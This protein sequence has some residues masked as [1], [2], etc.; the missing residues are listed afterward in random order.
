MA[1]TA[2]SARP[3]MTEKRKQIAEPLDPHYYHRNFLELIAF[4]DS[5]YRHLLNDG[6]KVFLDDYRALPLSAQQL[7]C[8]LVMRTRRYF[9]VS[10][11]AYPEIAE[12]DI[13]LDE[14]VTR[15]FCSAAKTEEAAVWV[16]L[17]RRDELQ[18]VLP[19]Q[20]GQRHSTWLNN[21]TTDLLL[22]SDLFGFTPLDLLRQLD[23]IYCTEHKDAFV[24]FQLLFFGDLHQDISSFVLRD[25]GLTRYESTLHQ[26][27]PLPF[28]SRTQLMAHRAYFDCITLYDDAVKCD[29]NALVELQRMLTHCCGD[30]AE[31]DITLKRRVEKWS[32]RI[33]RQLERVGAIDDAATIY[34]TITRPPARERLTRIRVKQGRAHDALALC[35][36][37][38]LRP[39]DAAELD[40]AQ[41][42]AQPLA[43]ALNE[44][45]PAVK[46]YSP[47][48]LSLTLPASKLPVEYATALHYAKTGKCFYVE[49]TLFTSVFGLAM[50][51]II[52]AP[53]E[54]AFFHPFQT[55]PSDFHASEFTER[56][57]SRFDKRL[58]QI[59]Q[60]GLAPFVLPNLHHKCGI[61]NP[62]V[63]WYAS[64][65]S[66]IIL[67][68][69]R[70]PVTDW[71]AIFEYLLQDIPAHRSGLPDLLYLPD[72]GSYL[73]LE[74]KGPGDQLQKHQRRWMKYF[75][76][77][78]IPHGVVNV[79]YT[80]EL[81][82][83]ALI[84]LECGLSQCTAQK[85]KQDD[86]QSS[87]RGTRQSTT[88][89]S[90]Q[91]HVLTGYAEH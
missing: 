6:E 9:R 53:I 26:D 29:R 12:P 56:R 54:G 84:R 22:Q 73:L 13:A 20:P 67:A 91:T 48:A 77:C 69:E 38:T 81:A 30:V 80:G 36:A 34:E 8:R 37:I 23:I 89:G 49:N 75:E 18:S 7:Y 88:R 4:V 43:K 57:R 63:N 62:L 1:L 70:I 50:W 66:L 35:K 28:T 82:D 33:A 47:P 39:G 2:N 72:D 25:L 24:N 64:K 27:L 74:V 71:L 44:D 58:Q 55:A 32:N 40:F 90:K 51:D 59:E 79:Q 65:R 85:S 78:Q 68:L 11:V 86:T 3:A 41:Q 46:K 76:R 31:Y 10:S 17:Y 16:S 14:L 15:G 87:S 60:Q 45:Y 42:F 19:V 52:F 61:S 21:S 83:E 5:N